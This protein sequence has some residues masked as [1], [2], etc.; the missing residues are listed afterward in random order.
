MKKI[1]LLSYTTVVILLVKQPNLVEPGFGINGGDAVNGTFSSDVVTA[2]PIRTPKVSQVRHCLK[3]CHKNDDCRG[4]KKECACDGDCGLSCINPK[5][6]CISLE[7]IKDG[8]FEVK[9]YNR[10]GAVVTYECNEGFVLVGESKRRCQGD[11]KWSSS[12]PSCEGDSLTRFIYCGLPPVIPNAEHDAEDKVRFLIGT[13]LLYKCRS[14]FHMEGMIT[15][16]CIGDGNWLGPKLTCSARSCGPPGDIEFGRRIGESDRYPARVTYFCDIG[17]SIIGKAFRQCQPNGKWSGKTPKCIAIQCPQVPAPRHGFVVGALHTYNSV[18]NFKCNEGY[19]LYGANQRRC[20]AHGN[21]DGEPARCEVVD[22]GYPE[23]HL[24]NGYIEG[25]KSTY[26]SVILFRC[27]IGMLFHGP[28]KS[29]RC[30]ADGKWSHP[31]PQCLRPCEVP[32]I[33]NGFVNDSTSGVIVEHGTHIKFACNPG[34]R[35]NT[36]SHSRCDNGTWTNIPHCQPGQPPQRVVLKPSSCTTRPPYIRNGLV[37]YQRIFHG[38][39]AKYKCHTGY[40]IVGSN[41][42]QCQYGKWIGT[43]PYCE[44]IYCKHPGTIK[45]GKILLMGNIGK[46]ENLSTKLIGQGRLLEFQCDKGYKLHGPSGTTCIGGKW[47]PGNKPK[48]IKGRHPNLLKPWLRG[49]KKHKTNNTLCRGRFNKVWFNQ[50]VYK[51]VNDC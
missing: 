20:T 44:P 10:V 45:N 28:S 6:R 50:V 43:K 36:T 24:V 47:S 12:P 26:D 51:N 18:I 33:M 25:Q 38:S 4:K 30:Q 13:R 49:Y 19:Q 41:I 48:C 34:H 5:R 2:C 1:F 17:Y 7:E 23:P 21:W 32:R 39:R 42:L 29:A 31:V 16:M 14:G 27:R 35:L 15:A 37:R 3:K 9:P 40:E 46:Y 22:C 11:G 8:Q